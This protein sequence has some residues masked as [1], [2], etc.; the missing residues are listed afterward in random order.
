M[1]RSSVSLLQPLL[2]LFSRL[3][4]GSRIAVLC[5]H[6]WLLNTFLALLLDPDALGSAVPYT[7]GAEGPGRVRPILLLSRYLKAGSVATIMETEDSM[8]PHMLSRT[9]PSVSAVGSGFDVAFVTCAR[10]AKAKAMMIVPS[11]KMTARPN[12]CCGETCSFR[13]RLRGRSM[14][15][16]SAT[17][18]ALVASLMERSA[19]TRS[20]GSLHP[21]RTC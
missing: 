11:E 20:S 19:R 7:G 9:G 10:R 6:R 21:A 13:R 4:L 2:P 5:L 14:M 8:K 18:S 12:F 16:A 17:T 3:R 1:G 15:R